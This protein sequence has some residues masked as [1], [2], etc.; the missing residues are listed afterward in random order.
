SQVPARKYHRTEWKNTG[1]AKHITAMRSSRPTA[2]VIALRL[3]QALMPASRLSACITN[4]PK[5]P[6][7]A[8]TNAA[9]AAWPAL[10][11]VIQ[12]S[13]APASAAA[14]A[15]IHHAFIVNERLIR[16]A[17]GLARKRLVA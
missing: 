5:L 3:P 7:P 8:A 17:T 1:A 6:Q 9:I 4:T 15:P 2:P 16:R 11:G 10:N 12:Y 14:N 13:S